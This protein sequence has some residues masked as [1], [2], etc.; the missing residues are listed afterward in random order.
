M[1]WIP[2]TRVTESALDKELGF[3]AALPLASDQFPLSSVLAEVQLPYDSARTA[4]G[5]P[6]SSISIIHHVVDL[7]QWAR[8]TV[9]SVESK[10]ADYPSSGERSNSWIQHRMRMR[11]EQEK[12][13]L[14]GKSDKQAKQSKDIKPSAQVK[15][16]ENQL[17][18]A[19]SA[20]I[21]IC[22]DTATD[23]LLEQVRRQALGISAGLT[24]LL[25]PL[26]SCQICMGSEEYGTRNPVA[27]SRA[28][29]LELSSSRLV[30]LCSVRN[31]C[32]VIIRRSLGTFT[33]SRRVRERFNYWVSLGNV[34]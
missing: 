11:D 22:T 23:N 33:H 26:N 6:T 4:S 12:K 21:V 20:V 5:G 10:Q 15:I 19:P 7:F 25:E 1:Y 17:H 31:A 9:Q 30:S 18:I 24:F 3:A 27:T 16:V 13:R 32:F 29:Q 8:L 34:V 14:T 28:Q 2:S